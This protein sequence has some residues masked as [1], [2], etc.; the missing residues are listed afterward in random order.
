MVGFC[1]PLKAA[2]LI[3]LLEI[4]LDTE[5]TLSQDYHS[6][7]WEVMEVIKNIIT[8]QLIQVIF[9]DLKKFIE[10]RI[11]K[12]SEEG[13]KRTL[14]SGQV[15]VNGGI[16]VSRNFNLRDCFGSRPI[17]DVL[18][19]YIFNQVIMTMNKFFELR[20]RM[21]DKQN[22]LVRN[23]IR[24]ISEASKYTGSNNDYIQN[25]NNL[26]KTIWKI[27]QL[28]EL[29]EGLKNQSISLLEE[30]SNNT[31]IESIVNNKMTRASQLNAYM[32]S[33][34]T[35][36]EVKNEVEIEFQQLILSILYIKK[37]SELGFNGKNTLDTK[38]ILKSIIKLTDTDSEI[39]KSLRRTSFKILRKVIEMENKEMNT[40]AAY[41]ETD[42]WEKYRN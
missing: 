12:I 5:K 2:C 6:P 18:E 19:N 8:T 15:D 10:I 28:K 40:P 1:Y 9:E 24:L 42:D 7:L 3:Y 20:L 13:K 34:V 22:N 25:I 29:T 17:I 14:L 4:Y 32:K 37:K 41:W 31:G 16:D 26:Y 38:E 30:V 36:E 23:S 27:P 11:K 33:A 39:E 35:S 21:N